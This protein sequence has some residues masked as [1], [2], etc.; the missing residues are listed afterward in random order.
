MR[1]DK[2]R[3][4][5]FFATTNDLTYLKSQTGNRRFWPVRVGRVRLDELARDRDQLWAEAST[6][7]RARGPLG[8]AQALWGDATALQNDRRDHDPWDD[9]LYKIVSAKK[10]PTP[11]GKNM[12]L[13]VST[14]D[15]FDLE[16]R[17]M[18]EKLTDT[19]AKRL[20]FVMRR[21]GW[22]GP[23]KIRIGDETVRGYVKM[24]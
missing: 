22:D 8:L 14:R 2:P 6:V 4:C 18:N 24:G 1:V 3:R 19:L 9:I 11:D 5:I 15:I 7:E 10:Y 23:K 16:L 12:E 20:A 13:R 21:L 17:I